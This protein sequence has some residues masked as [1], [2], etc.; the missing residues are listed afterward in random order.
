LIEDPTRALERIELPTE[1]IVRS[2][3]R[4]YTEL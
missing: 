2:T 3:C 4:S 1:L